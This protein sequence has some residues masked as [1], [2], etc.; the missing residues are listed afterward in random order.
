MTR[1]KV[2]P[3]EWALFIG[4]ILALILFGFATAPH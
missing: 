4:A 1:D 2:H 3:V